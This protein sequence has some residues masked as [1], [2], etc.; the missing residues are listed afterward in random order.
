ML[1]K[2]I[3]GQRIRQAR[4]RKGLSQEDLAHLI[5]RDQRAVSEYENGKRGI[6]VTDLPN[7]AEALN[8]PLLYFYEGDSS[9]DDLD[10]LMLQEMRRLPTLSAKQAAISLVRVLNNVLEDGTI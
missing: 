4:E 2:Q 1:D 8:V 10:S 9:L 3:L 6:A 5:A 7:L